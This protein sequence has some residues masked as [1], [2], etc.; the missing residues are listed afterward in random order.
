MIDGSGQANSHTDSWCHKTV[1]FGCHLQHC[2]SSLRC[3]KVSSLHFLSF[4]NRGLVKFAV[5]SECLIFLPCWWLRSWTTTCL[6]KFSAEQGA[7]GPHATNNVCQHILMRFL[8]SLESFYQYQ[9]MKWMYPRSHC[10][11]FSSKE[12]GLITDRVL[13]LPRK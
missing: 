3:L 2:F 7:V 1:G 12:A 13:T 9:C 8:A 4:K 6:V 10:Q 11:P 5:L